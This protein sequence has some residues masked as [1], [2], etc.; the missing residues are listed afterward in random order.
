MAYLCEL[1]TDQRLYLENQGMQTVVTTVS[2][3]LGQQQQASNSFQTGNWTSTPEVFQTPGGVVL[4]IKTAQGEHYIQVQGGSMS[5]MNSTPAFGSSQQMQVQQV[6]STPAT[7]MPPMEPMQPIEPMQPMKPMKMG[8]M[9]M[10]MNPMEMRMGN[11]E[12][13]MGAPTQ[14]TKRF[15]PQCGTSV[16][17]GD[18]FCASCGHRLH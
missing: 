4:K 1:G 7:S 14:S 16:D 17:P 11:M 2:S 3:S 9:E 8:D 18:R 10:N 6:A 5:A 15:C 12:M 13:R